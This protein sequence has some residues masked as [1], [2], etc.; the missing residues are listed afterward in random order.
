MTTSAILLSGGQGLRM[1]GPTPKQYLPLQGKP[2]ILHALEALLAF[3]AWQEIAIV[4]EQEYEP[5]FSPYTS[6][7][8]LCFARPGKTRQDSVWQGIKALTLP[9]HSVCI[10][11][12]AR[13]LLQKEE[14]LAVLRE[15]QS[16]GAAALAVPVRSTI[17]E[18]RSDRSIQKTLDR[19]LLWEMQT[20]Q[21]VHY[22]LLCQGLTMQ[23]PV[24]DDISLAEQ[25]G[26]PSKVV[27]GSYSNIKITTQEDLLLA[28]ILCSRIK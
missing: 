16:M 14:L 10:H 17:K 11:D 2:I 25:L 22:D 1:Q 12:G 6:R 26:H 15:G 20:P 18:V 27:L 23:T 3:D 8:S 21:V 7:A 28:E 4:C 24:T 9:C 19:A 13:P 5:L